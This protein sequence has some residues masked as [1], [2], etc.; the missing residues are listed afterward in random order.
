MVFLIRIVAVQERQ[1]AAEPRDPAPDERFVQ[2][3]KHR[4]DAVKGWGGQATLRMCPHL[5][6]FRPPVSRAR[7]SVRGLSLNDG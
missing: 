4:H 5:D 6:W 2:V 1:D 7:R 3:E